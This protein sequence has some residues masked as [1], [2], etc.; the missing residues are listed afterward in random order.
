MGLLVGAVE[1]GNSDRVLS[2]EYVSAFQSGR[3]PLKAVFTP[4]GVDKWDVVFHFKFHGRAHEFAGRAAGSLDEGP[5]SGT[6]ENESRQR[7]FSFEGTIRDGEFR[8][9]HAEIKRTGERRTGSLT[10]A[11]KP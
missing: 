6:V 10:L 7:T 3:Q 4:T 8:G 2:G 11:E 9:T 5:L 1:G